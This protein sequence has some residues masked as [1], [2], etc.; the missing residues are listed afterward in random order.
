MKKR[1]FLVLA[2]MALAGCGS[3]GDPDL[4]GNW[5]GT[6]KTTSNGAVTQS[7]IKATLAQNGTVVTGNLTAEGTDGTFPGTVAGNFNGSTLTANF[8]P[9]D[10]TRCPYSATLVYS[11]NKLSGIGTAYNCSV[12]SSFEINLTR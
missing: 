1:L 12:S 5:T 2:A 11:D 3:T 6:G 10:A 4:S 8:S 9:S 7:T